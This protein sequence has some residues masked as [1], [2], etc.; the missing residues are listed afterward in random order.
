MVT[1]RVLGIGDLR[2]WFGG[3]A[4]VSSLVF[5]ATELAALTTSTLRYLTSGGAQ[6]YSAT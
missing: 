1:R 2:V 6:V 5:R 4:L 3:C